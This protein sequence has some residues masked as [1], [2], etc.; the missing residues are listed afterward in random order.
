MAD[1]TMLETAPAID[2]ATWVERFGDELFHHA[3]MRLRDANAAE[4]V[5]QETFLA[6]VRKLDQFR[7]EGSEVGWLK[8]ILRRK[9][10]D[11][12]RRQ[13]RRDQQ[14]EHLRRNFQVEFHFCALEDANETLVPIAT[15]PQKFVDNEKL[16]RQTKALSLIHI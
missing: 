4:E 1:D 16:W 11:F 8:G 15:D 6:A 10:V 9:I 14:I 5:V 12:V 2:P 7:G 13:A 3:V